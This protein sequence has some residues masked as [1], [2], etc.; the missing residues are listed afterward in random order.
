MRRISKLA[1][2]LSVT[3][4]ALLAANTKQLPQRPPTDPAWPGSSLL[5]FVT[6]ISG[7]SVTGTFVI[8]LEQPLVGCGAKFLSGIA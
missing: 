8:N 6:P 1:F 3:A 4:A 5:S 2:L 7:S